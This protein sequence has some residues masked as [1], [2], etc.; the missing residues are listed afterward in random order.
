MAERKPKGSR[1]RASL[2]A[3]LLIHL[4]LLAAAIL[5]L[6]RQGPPPEPR[7]FEVMLVPLR[8]PIKPIKRRPPA[9]RPAGP[10]ST[11]P[12]AQVV[13]QTGMPVPPSVQAPMPSGEDPEGRAKATALLRG[14]FGCSEAKLVRLSQDELDRCERWR[15]A[16][17]NPDLALPAPIAPDKR[18]WYDAAIAAR[19]AP[20]HPPGFVCGLLIDGIHLI[21]PKPPP[22]SLHVGSVPCYVIPPKWTFSEEADI[23]TPSRHAA[24]GTALQFTPQTYLSNGRGPSP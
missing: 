2:G 12:A 23:E 11:A 10:A 21:K 24:A 14:S 15:R 19:G 5:S 1:V 3:S 4:G 20:S 22:H 16:H 7:G 6:P 18:A 9:T 17:V 8:V 13:P